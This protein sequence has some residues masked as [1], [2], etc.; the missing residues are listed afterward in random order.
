[1]SATTFVAARAYPDNQAGRIQRVQ[2]LLGPDSRPGRRNAPR[3]RPPH[4]GCQTPALPDAGMSA[5]TSSGGWTGG[6]IIPWPESRQLGGAEKGLRGA[7]INSFWKLLST[8]GRAAFQWA[9]RVRPSDEAVVEPAREGM[10]AMFDRWDYLD[11]S[12]PHMTAEHAALAAWV[13]EEAL[14][15]FAP[16]K[17]PVA[18]AMLLVCSPST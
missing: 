4:Q 13:W 17:E 5:L 8:I 2:P 9:T 12:F 14:P 15:E 1:M 10:Q 6:G 7:S 16:Q 3:R 18:G 11:G